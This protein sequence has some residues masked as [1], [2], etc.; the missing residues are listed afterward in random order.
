MSPSVRSLDD[1]SA[2]KGPQTTQF[3]IKLSLLPIWGKVN[4]YMVYLE[5]HC[6]GT[7]KKFCLFSVSRIIQFISLLRVDSFIQL[8][9]RSLPFSLNQT[10]CCAIFR[11][12]IIVVMATNVSL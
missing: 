6:F 3:T 8:L 12:V 5:L 1:L 11:P 7:V 9:N 10:E 2:L 4:V